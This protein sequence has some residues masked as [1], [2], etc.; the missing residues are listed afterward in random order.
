M[1]FNSKPLRKRVDWLSILLFVVLVI[2]GWFAIC[3]ASYDFDMSRLLAPGSRPVM[4]LVWIGFA[5]LI[6]FSV[7]MIEADLFETFST[8]FYLLILGVLVLTIFIAPDIKGSRSWLVIGP[9]RIQPAEFAKVATALCLAWQMNKHGFKLAGFKSYAITFGIIFLPAALIL[10]QNETG[11]ALVFAAFFMPLYREGLK[12]AFLGIAFCAILFFV[13]AMKLQGEYWWQYTPADTWSIYAMIYSICL[14]LMRLYTRQR[15]L[16]YLIA[17]LLPLVLHIGL[18]IYA[19]FYPVNYLWAVGLPL[20]ALVFWCLF[21]A[22]KKFLLNYLLI[23]IFAI[24]SLAYVQSVDYVF[25]EIMQPHQQMRIKVALGI[26]QDLRGGGYN[27]DQSKIAI[28]SGGLTGK[29]FLKGTQ[30]KLKYVPEQDTDFIFCTIGEEQGFLGSSFLLILFA[31][32]ILR[33]AYLAERSSSTFTRVYGYSVAAILLFHLTVNVGM[34][35]GLVPVIGI[36]L[37]LFSYGG[38]SLWA[39]TIMVFVM[40][41]LDADRDF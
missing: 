14:I 12:G 22:A 26:E 15:G 24:G 17:L 30:T 34:V 10:L 11:S 29:G 6:A 36:P 37:P 18:A 16:V 41:R 39:F 7:L 23:A 27:V 19:I 5:S 25:D 32:L 20:A 40:L 31:A 21:W 3:G 1:S 9:L 38:S 2:S 33:L 8:L 35:L 28:G 13:T 4:Q